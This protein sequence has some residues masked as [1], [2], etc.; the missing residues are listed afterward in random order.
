M[1]LW[2][3]YMGTTYEQLDVL[4]DAEES[5]VVLA[6]DKRGKNAHVR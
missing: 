2:E 3:K 4:K 6:Y 1:K 5:K